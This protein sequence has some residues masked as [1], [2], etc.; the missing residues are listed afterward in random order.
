M[1]EGELN[2]VPVVVTWCLF[3]ISTEGSEISSPICIQNIIKVISSQQIL[4]SL[5][6]SSLSNSRHHIKLLQ[7]I[8]VWVIGD[9][10]SGVFVP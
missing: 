10:A 2:L 6:G 3:L 8:Q 7:W 1:S 4:T 9:Q 5:A